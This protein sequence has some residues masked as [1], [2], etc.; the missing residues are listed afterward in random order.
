MMIDPLSGLGPQKAEF[1]NRLAYTYGL[2]QERHSL[3]FT[4]AMKVFRYLTSSRSL[5]PNHKR[6]NTQ[7]AGPTVSYH[8]WVKEKITF[9][10]QTF[11]KRILSRL[12]LKEDLSD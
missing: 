11:F 3:V 1:C 6:Q 7:E 12:N 2:H 4:R 10:T 8:L 5:R 9:C